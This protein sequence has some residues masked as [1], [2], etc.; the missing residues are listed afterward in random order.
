MVLLLVAACGETTPSSN[1]NQPRILS[2][3]FGLDDSLPAAIEGVCPGGTG[4]DGLP[5][6]VTAQLADLDLP[7]SAFRVIRSSGADG[8]V[9]CA[10]LRPAIGPLER[11][12]V[13]LVGDLGE[14]PSDPPT[15]VEI[16]GPLALADGGM[17]THVVFDDVS[18]LEQGAR[19]GLAE[20]FVWAEIAP[21]LPDNLNQCPRTETI[22][23]VNVLWQG[24]ITAAGGAPLGERERQGL[25][26]TV[27]EPSG[28]QR[29]ILPFAL[30]DLNDR[31]NHLHL[32]LDTT[33]E[34]IAVSA[35]AGLFFDPREDPNPATGAPVAAGNV[36]QGTAQN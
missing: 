23:I 13:L 26:V 14:Y 18:G 22:Q 16:T 15:R 28:A 34:A 33:D 6:I 24:G 10:S 30:G 5:M 4:L 17:L 32:C 31:D 36:L 2:A 12:T 21:L 7:A 11:R 9:R 20:R 1:S 29:E 35:D 25:R 19:I 27:R 3:F 8:V